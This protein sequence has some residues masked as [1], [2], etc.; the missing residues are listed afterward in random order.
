[1]SRT[2]EL[3]AEVARLKQ[4]QR[5][6]REK[7]ITTARK[8]AKDHGLCS[9]VDQAIE[10]AGLGPAWKHI[11]LKMTVPTTIKLSVDGDLIEGLSEDEMKS[12]VAE[13]IA[14]S[15]LTMVDVTKTDGLVRE[16][17][18]Y[19]GGGRAGRY[20]IPEPIVELGDIVVES[21]QT[22]ELPEPPPSEAPPGWFA[23]YTSADGRVKHFF[24]ESMANRE[25]LMNPNATQIRYSGGSVYLRSACG[26]ANWLYSVVR[27]SPRG[28]NRVCAACQSR[29]S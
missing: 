24:S 11:E 15:L 26:S 8:Y 4:E 13:K 10:E 18:A 1:M 3:E 5:E 19:G 29:V 21:T 14:P 17:L 20:A 6:L 28:E 9:V 25:D 2:E 12:Y 7:V 16:K 23:A 22:I 27:N